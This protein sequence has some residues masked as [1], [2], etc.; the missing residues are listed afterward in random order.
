MQFGDTADYKS[1][2]HREELPDTSN[3]IRISERTTNAGRLAPDVPIFCMSSPLDFSSFLATPEPP[4][5]GPGPRAGVQ[6]QPELS[7]ALDNLF[8]QAELPVERQQLIRA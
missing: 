1:A 8:S 3:F 4:E 2:L 7:R 5:L 6:P